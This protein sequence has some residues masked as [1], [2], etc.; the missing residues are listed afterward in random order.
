MRRRCLVCGAT[1]S[2][3]VSP[4]LFGVRSFQP[5]FKTVSFKR[6]A[7]GGGSP[8][9][10]QMS[11]VIYVFGDR[12]LLGQVC[13]LCLGVPELLQ[14][15]IGCSP[16]AAAFGNACRSWGLFEVGHIIR[17]CR[18]GGLLSGLRGCGGRAGEALFAVETCGGL[19]SRACMPDPAPSRPCQLLW[20]S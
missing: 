9:V 4:M 5:H 17:G 7:V 13:G 6:G 12:E 10:E 19:H 8:H 16:S 20:G 3:C 11:V 15:V 1:W 18:E 14:A 2:S